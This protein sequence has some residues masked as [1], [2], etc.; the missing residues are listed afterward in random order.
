MRWD[1]GFMSE[2]TDDPEEWAVPPSKRVP[3][4]NA[5]DRIP[6][7]EEQARVRQLID[8]A[9]LIHQQAHDPWGISWAAV[10]TSLMALQSLFAWAEQAQIHPGYRTR[11]DA[12]MNAEEL[13]GKLGDTLPDG[14][15]PT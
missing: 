5:P 1:S 14:W 3:V 7:P 12:P 9:D 10:R 2:S 11:I 6:P 13:L 8:W 4:E 15:G